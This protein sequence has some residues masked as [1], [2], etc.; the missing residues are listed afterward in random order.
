MAAAGFKAPW[1]GFST[2][3]GTSATLAQALRPFPQYT[4][5]NMAQSANVGNMTYHSLQAK[6]EKNISNG[7][8]LLSSYT[9]SKTLTD[10]SSALGGFFSSS[11]RDQYNRRLEKALA[12]FD[13][14]HR[15]VTA[16]NYEAANRARKALF[17]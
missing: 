8:F 7:L 17:R 15:S 12:V 16:F 10:A 4:N 13:V 9:W 14:P 11:A 6:V 3:L 1:P 2:A 5:I